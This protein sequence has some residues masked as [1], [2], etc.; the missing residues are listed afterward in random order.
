[1]KAQRAAWRAFDDVFR[2]TTG[3]GLESRTTRSFA[4]DWLDRT[5]GEVAPGT[6]D[7][8]NAVTAGFL[9]VQLRV[10]RVMTLS[11]RS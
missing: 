10:C 9:R 3:T 6:W 11:N 8:Y 1:M 5:R 2:L 7:R 4:N